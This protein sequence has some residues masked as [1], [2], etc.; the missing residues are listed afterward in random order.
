MEDNKTM[1][2]FKKFRELAGLRR[3]DT[4]SNL[5]VTVKTIYNWE[6]GSTSPDADKLRGM[7]LLYKCSSDELLALA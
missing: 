3:E 5:G 1:N 4:A 2:N 6:N 7:A